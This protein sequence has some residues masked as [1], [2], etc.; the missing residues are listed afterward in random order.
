MFKFPRAV[1]NLKFRRPSHRDVFEHRGEWADSRELQSPTLEGSDTRDRQEESQ[2]TSVWGSSSLR[3]GCANAQGQSRNRR[4][5]EMKKIL[6]DARQW[7]EPAQ[8]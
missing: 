5:E 2:P 7:D 8:S 3:G 1:L 4:V 6:S